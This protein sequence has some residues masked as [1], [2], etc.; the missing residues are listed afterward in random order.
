MP[1]ELGIS[2]N[3]HPFRMDRKRKEPVQLYIELTNDG[4][5]PKMLSL[6]IDLTRQF[7]FDKGGLKSVTAKRIPE[8]KAGER[9]NFYFDIY[10]RQFTDVGDHEVNFLI[11]EHYR[12]YDYVL[13]QHKVRL[14][15]SVV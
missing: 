3:F 10:P 5:E 4:K 1:G 2:A 6:E 8:L 15:L 13:K 7:G 11:K 9:M 12:N 14:S